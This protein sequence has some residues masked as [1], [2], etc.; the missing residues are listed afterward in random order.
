MPN[1][2][3]KLIRR[4]EIASNTMAFYLEKPSGFTFKAGQYISVTLVDPPETDDEGHTRVFTIA[5]APYE[6][7]LMIATR[8]RNK[9]FKRIIKT[10][11]FNTQ[12]KINGP[13]GD[14]ILHDDQSL[15]AVFFTGGIGVTPILSILRQTA[16]DGLNRSIFVFFSNRTPEEAPFL[17]ELK[18]LE[19]DIKNY[20]FVPTMTRPRTSN[21][22]WIGETGHIGKEML[23]KYIKDPSLPIYYVVG[24][25]TMALATKSM[26]EKMEITSANIRFEEF[27]GY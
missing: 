9:A 10:M 2:K 24:P 21:H 8:M 12:I 14:F 4:I 5:S 6:N 26:L 22:P 19:S 1:Y 20:L 23:I 7:K 25:P 11:S 13:Y 17:V 18:K 16:Y 27:S 15:P 3:T